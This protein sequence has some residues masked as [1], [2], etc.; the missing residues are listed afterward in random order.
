MEE[1]DEEN[2]TVDDGASEATNYEGLMQ[3]GGEGL[4]PGEIPAGSR[5]AEIVASTPVR[6]PQARETTVDLANSANEQRPFDVEKVLHEM[7]QIQQDTGAENAK[8]IQEAVS[9]IAELSKVLHEKTKS[10]KRGR[11]EG[12]DDKIRADPPVTND[13][14][15]LQVSDGLD[16]AHSKICWEVR[17]QWRTINKDP[18]DYWK[19]EGEDKGWP[20]KIE[21]NL[22]GQVF[23]DHL[24]P[25][26][27]SDKA[28]SWLHDVS[29]TLEVR[30]FLH[31]N[32]K[33]RSKKNKRMEIEA[34]E[35]EGGDGG[36]H[37][38]T[39]ISW[40]EAG[41][42]KEMVQAV[43][44]YTAAVFMVRPWDFSGLVLI[45]CLHDVNFFALTSRSAKEQRDLVSEF[46]EDCFLANA[47]AMAKGKH[48][49]THKEALELAGKNVSKKNGMAQ[50][51]VAQ[52]DVYGMREELR[53][54]EEEVKKL[55]ADVSR[56]KTQLNE[57]KQKKKG[58][59]YND[60]TSRING[61]PIEEGQARGGGAGRLPHGFVEARKKT[62]RFFNLGDCRQGSACTRGEHA[63][64]K[65]VGQVMCGSVDHARPDHK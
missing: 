39:Y 57:E 12:V 49:L 9:C 17:R 58:G 18:T 53:A 19:D 29:K 44:N 61:K 25:H 6:R 45:R 42:V 11:E 5:E 47:R 27:I 4:T 56:L 46:V 32:S 54:K 16:D 65:Q 52:C 55:K 10:E 30:Y 35:S 13:F 1:G 41:T 64:S 31:S 3:G 50:H 62:C 23:L 36:M 24:V 26:M 37:V 28:L 40:N 33:T 15:N 59:G 34:R 22:A 7:A 2:W 60:Y 43:L 8:C 48:P 20:R 21:P 63:C 14:K 38:E 51:L